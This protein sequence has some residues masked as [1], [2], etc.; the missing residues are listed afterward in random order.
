MDDCIFCKI[1]KGE[2]PAKK[3]K[4]T[5]NLLVFEDRSPKAPVHLLIVPKKHIEDIRQDSGTIWPAIGKLAVEIAKEKSLSGFRLVHNVGD[6]ALVK[7]M[8]VHLLGEVK[9]DREV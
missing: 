5:P 2:V 6:A 8:H 7:H 4:E 1:I 3:D 9:V